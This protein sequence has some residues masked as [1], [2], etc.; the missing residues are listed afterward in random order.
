MRT[1][2]TLAITT[3]PPADALLPTRAGYWQKA[4]LRVRTEKVATIWLVLGKHPS[5][6]LR[7]W[8][9]Y[10]SQH[11]ALLHLTWRKS[12]ESWG[13]WRQKTLRE[14]LLPSPQS[15]VC[16]RSWATDPMGGKTATAMGY[17][18]CEASRSGSVG[19]VIPTRGPCHSLL[20]PALY[21]WNYSLGVTIK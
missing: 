12:R 16:N 18:G 21:P 7:Q 17:S 3:A 8:C 4:Q 5:P 6:C 20:S 9:N 13:R 19:T 14:T 11:L 15:L 1:Q 10:Q 2:W